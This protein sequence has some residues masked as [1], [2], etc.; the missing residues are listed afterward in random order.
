[1]DLRIYIIGPLMVLFGIAII[2]W[3]FYGIL[4]RIIMASKRKTGFLE[5][6]MPGP[7]HIAMW[8]I[9]IPLVILQFIFWMTG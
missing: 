2:I 6:E 1:M 4:Y 8:V 3:F 9:A 7:Y 5:V